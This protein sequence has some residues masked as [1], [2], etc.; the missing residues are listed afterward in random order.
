MNEPQADF[1]A[2]WL[3]RARSDLHLG[4][5]ALRT[6]GVL[7]ED[8][9][10]HA[11]QCAEKALKALL[12]NLD[13]SFPKTHTIELLL[14]LLKEHSLAIPAGVDEAFELSQYAVQTR[15][16]G[17]WEPVTK[18]EAAR[19]LERAGLVLAWVENQMK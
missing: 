17:E 7:P 8:A 15:Y 9:C 11:Q 1:V 16:P 14:D 6:R 2:Q 12:L 13:I 5:A 19:A 4:R 10:F 3:Q 18:K